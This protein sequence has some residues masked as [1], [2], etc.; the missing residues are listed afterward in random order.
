M[1]LNKVVWLNGALFLVIASLSIMMI[2][3]ERKLPDAPPLQDLRS[4]VDDA[5]SAEL[6]TG[7]EARREH[8]NFGRINI[9]ETLVP[10]PTPTP[11]PAPTPVPPPDIRE[12]IEFWRLVGATS[13]FGI[14]QDT[15]SKQD[16][17]MRVGEFREE[18]FKNKLYKVYLKS[19]VSM[20]SVTLTMEA[21][22]KA[23]ETTL[24]IKF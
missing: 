1:N 5:L 8:E 18:R 20:K 22:G 13:S 11:T 7:G 3:E 15:K 9:F 19:T 16:F 12:V 14:F 4:V 17:T 24:E 23:M 6:G 2:T 10:L 21:E